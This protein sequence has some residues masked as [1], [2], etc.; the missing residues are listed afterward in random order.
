MNLN[1]L[2]LKTDEINK[3][4]YQYCQYIDVIIPI[5]LWGTVENLLIKSTLINNNFFYDNHPVFHKTFSKKKSKLKDKN[6]IFA[7]ILSENFA[8]T[9]YSIYKEILNLKTLEEIRKHYVILRLNECI[10]NKFKYD[11][12]ISRFKIDD[13]LE[14]LFYFSIPHL[15]IGYSNCNI[16]NYIQGLEI[17]SDLSK[18][19]YWFNLDELSLIEMSH[20]L[21]WAFDQRNLV[22]QSD[23]INSP[24]NPTIFSTYY[25]SLG[26]FLQGE[27]DTRWQQLLL[28]TCIEGKN[29]TVS[30]AYFL[31]IIPSEDKGHLKPTTGNN[32]FVIDPD[33]IYDDDNIDV[34]FIENPIVNPNDVYKDT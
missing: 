17:T 9:E 27:Q 33:A 11:K 4:V 8:I 2:L 30:N 29:V 12:S 26:P 34:Q 6:L 3:H 20:I 24:K 18:I 10:F 31:N 14:F 21:T 28:K 32:I 1:N 13:Y 5:G 19:I 16:I 25:L 22:P 15:T 23:F 7:S